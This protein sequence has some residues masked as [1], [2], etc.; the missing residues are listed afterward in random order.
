[1]TSC[2]PQKSAGGRGESVLDRPLDSLVAF[3]DLVEDENWIYE[4]GDESI[5]SYEGIDGEEYEN[6]SITEEIDNNP[7]TALA[8]DSE[9]LE[10]TQKLGNYMEKVTKKESNETKSDEIDYEERLKRYALHRERKKK[11]KLGTASYMPNM[12]SKMYR[13]WLEEQ[14]AKVIPC[15]LT[16]PLVCQIWKNSSS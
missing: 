5:A 1:M 10:L 15:F 8:Q 6:N 12:R 9:V 14:F 11:K 16:C 2:L 3:G 7:E 13:E 4:G